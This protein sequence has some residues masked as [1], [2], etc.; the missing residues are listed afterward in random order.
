M[1]GW[2][3]LVVRDVRDFRHFDPWAQ[4]EVACCAGFLVDWKLREVLSRQEVRSAREVTC[5]VGFTPLPRTFVGSLG[6]Q[7]F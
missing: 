2:E 6:D 3:A 4:L 5:D 1:L 7:S